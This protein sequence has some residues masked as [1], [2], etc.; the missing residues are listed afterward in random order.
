MLAQALTGVS[1]PL[2]ATYLR[3][4]QG[5]DGA[6]GDGTSADEKGLVLLAL[7]VSG[8]HGTTTTAG[9]DWLA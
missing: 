2:A 8:D 1:D 7:L 5:G 3:D 6:W 4:R 9:L